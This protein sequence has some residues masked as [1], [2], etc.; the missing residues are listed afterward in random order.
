[1]AAVLDITWGGATANSY[2]S[3]AE[4]NAYHEKRLHTSTWNVSRTTPDATKISALIWATSLIDQLFEFD[5]TKIST[6]QN[7]S[8]PRHGMLNREGWM[9]DQAT[10]PQWIINAVAEYAYWL[11]QSDLL[12]ISNDDETNSGSSELLGFKEIKIGTITLKS[13]IG[14]SKSSGSS[15][16]SI[17]PNSVLL[18]LMPYGN[19]FSSRNRRIVR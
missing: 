14:E 4:A 13:S 6:T 17:I 11:V 16:T 5:G 9:E 2:A 18:M 1:M 19:L 3:I 8:C 10:K 12:A 7:L 15:T